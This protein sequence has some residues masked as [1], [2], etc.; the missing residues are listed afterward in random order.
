VK[1]D[2]RILVC[3]GTGLVGSAIARR[4]SRAKHTNVLQP[5]RDQLDLTDRG[6]VLRYFEEERPEYVFMAA[7]RVGGIMANSTYPADFIRDNLAIELNVVDA[8]WRAGV[9]KLLMLGSSCI[10]PRESPQPI[11]EEY[12]LAGP[13]EP[14]NAPYAIAKI[15]GI[16]LCQSY[17]KQ[18]GSRFI[19]AMPTNLYGPGDN[20][21]LESSH[22]I[23]AL[24]RKFDDAR[25]SGASTVTVW[26]SGN[27]K[28]EFLYVDDLADAC[29]FLMERYEEPLPINVGFGEDIAIADL[30]ALIAAIVG[31]DGAIQFDLTKPD[32]TPRKLLD[33]GRINA[34]GWV[35]STH[36]TAGLKR[37][38]E[39]Y[40]QTDQT[41]DPRRASAKRSLAGARRL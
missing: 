12:L 26:G 33:V 31:F 19:S 21:D 17:A 18:Y 1:S 15:A 13:L 24:I 39:W 11:R 5:G 23:P 3:G 27:P 30:A 38:Y 25:E 9:S 32:G 14:T 35:A 6:A 40:L 22:V 37:T 29:V 36:L 8:A 34:L 41:L 2:S 10:Y 4:L 16:A 7:A 28:R 20:F